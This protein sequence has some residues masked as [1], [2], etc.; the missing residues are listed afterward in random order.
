MQK[1]Q[2][3]LRACNLSENRYDNLLIWLEERGTYP[4]LELQKKCR[5]KVLGTVLLR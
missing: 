4:S 5:G 2:P 3:D 1:K